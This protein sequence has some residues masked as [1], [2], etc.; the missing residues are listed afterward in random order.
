MAP[1]I[2]NKDHYKIAADIFSFAV[3]MYEVF[4]W[5][6]AFPKDE[7]KFPWKIAEFVTCGLRRPKTEIMTDEEF[8]EELEET[9]ICADVGVQCSLRICDQLRERAKRDKVK[10]KDRE[11]EL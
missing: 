9:L 5:S 7:F 3:T 6:E 4:N 2:L 8:F 11:I 1:E 10:N